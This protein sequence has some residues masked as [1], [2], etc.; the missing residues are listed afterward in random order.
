[1]DNLKLT[2]LISTRISHDLSGTIGAIYNGTELLQDDPDFAADATD[3]IQTSSASLMSRM[4]FFRQAFGLPK[5]GDDTLPE[6]LKTFSVPFEVTGTAKNNLQ[7][8]LV[9]ALTD[10]F[11]RGADIAITSDCISAHGKA[12][13][14]PTPLFTLSTDGSGKENATNAPAFFAFYLSQQM[15]ATIQPMRPDE[16]QIKIYIR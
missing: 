3:L 10:Y 13:K 12:L 11:Y 2:Q 8:L 4:R 5:E 15:N 7:R 14:D 9:M 16:T 1:M 6:Y